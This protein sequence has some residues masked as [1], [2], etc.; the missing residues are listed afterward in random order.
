MKKTL[1]EFTENILNSKI[2]AN[3]RFDDYQQALQTKKLFDYLEIKTVLDVGANEGQYA[4]FLRHEV[5]Y[6]GVIIS[7]EPAKEP[8][9]ILEKKAKLDSNWHCVCAAL[10]EEPGSMKLNVMAYSQYNSLL[11]PDKSENFS[12]DS[13]VVESYDIELKTLNDVW[14]ELQ[15]DY[16][17]SSLYLKMDTQG[18]DLSVLKGGNKVL[19]NVRGIQSELSIIPLYKN[20]PNYID[21]MQYLEERN[22]AISAMH[23]VFMDRKMRLMEFDG[24]F[25]NTLSLEHL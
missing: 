12:H 25:I 21:V 3:W 7:F 18:S 16:D 22:F 23:P 11:T 1:H 24:V 6:E 17:L 19:Q 9:K 5:G 10:G 8:F 20:M 4:T 14:I 2:I 15:K 13:T